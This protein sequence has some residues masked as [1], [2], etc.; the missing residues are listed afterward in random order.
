[1]RSS[2]G[3]L[4]NSQDVLGEVSSR[5]SESRSIEELRDSITG[6]WVQGTILVQIGV[7]D[8]DP[9]V[10]AEIANTVAEVLPLYDVSNGAWSSR[11]ATRRSRRRPSPVPASCSPPGSPSRWR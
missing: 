10:A 1:M 7:S 4:A 11:P 8:S 5:L 6:S 9:V 2:M 3:E